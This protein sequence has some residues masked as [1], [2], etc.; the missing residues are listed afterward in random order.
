MV[1][2]GLATALQVTGICIYCDQGLQQFQPNSQLCLRIF[3]NKR[4]T[5]FGLR[6]VFRQDC[7]GTKR[8]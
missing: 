8:Y 5:G 7:R 3:S 1:T 2:G 4:T 6:K